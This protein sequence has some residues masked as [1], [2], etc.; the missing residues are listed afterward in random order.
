MTHNAYTYEAYGVHTD[1][2]KKTTLPIPEIG[3]GDVLIKVQA[4]AIN[5]VDFKIMEGFIKDWPQS[6]PIIPGWDVAGTIEKTNSKDFQV[7]DEVF[8]YTR[9]A[10]D[11]TEEHP[12]CSSEAIG[13]LDGTH[14]GYVAVKAWK[15]AK[16]PNSASIEEAAAVPLAALTAYQAL[17]DKAGISEGKT[18]LIVAASGGV[19]SFAVGLAKE[20]G[21]TVIGTCSARNFDYVKGLG[22]SDVRDYN[23]EDYLKGIEAD[24]VFD[25][26]GGKSTTEALAV[27]KPDGIIVSIVEFGI[28]D[29]AQKADRK[30]VAFLVQPTG[31]QLR[32]IGKLIDDG[33]VKIPNITTMP[34][35]NIQ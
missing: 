1:V 21:A 30:G 32:T 18:V 33:K 20:A 10:F 4:S 23:E 34:F 27:L 12:E 17:H 7:G 9:P 13:T 14:A 22:A 15:V 5:P 31:D 3:E 26:A 28:A 16:K 24:I 25:C 19:G 8:S 35:D 29:I 11:M 2:L 6:F